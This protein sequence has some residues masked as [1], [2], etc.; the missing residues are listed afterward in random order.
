MC[1]SNKGHKGTVHAS[2]QI[3]FLALE[4]CWCENLQCL[5]NFSS[6]AAHEYL[7]MAN[8]PYDCAENYNF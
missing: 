7:G 1:P 3:V 5:A 4:E 8:A 6:H 2:E